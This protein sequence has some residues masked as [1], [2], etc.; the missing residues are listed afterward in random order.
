MTGLGFGNGR[1]S[2]AW[3]AGTGLDL[4]TFEFIISANNFGAILQANDAKE[5][6]LSFGSRWRF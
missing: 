3:S 4:G 6:N 2:V 5:I 1:A